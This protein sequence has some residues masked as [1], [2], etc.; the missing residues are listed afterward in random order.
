MVEILSNK[1]AASR[2]QIMVA[3]AAHE[4]GLQQKDI[5]QQI[6]ITPQA[7]S[8]YV[9]ELVKRGMLIYEG[10]SQ[11]R[12]SMEGVDW[13]LRQMLEMAD[14]LEFA[15]RTVANIQVSAAIAGCDLEAGQQVGLTMRDGLL[16]ATDKTNTEATGKTITAAGKGEDVGITRI[17]G[18]IKLSAGDVS[19]IEIATAREGGSKQADSRLLREALS[20]HFPVVAQGI[21]AV[22]ALKKAAVRFNGFHG[23]AEVALDAARAGLSPAVVSTRNDIP[24][25]LNRLEK[26]GLKY[27]LVNVNKKL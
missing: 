21:E 12:V 24:F 4:P 8:S 26:A 5:A 20:N 19:I 13:I 27:Y 25:L 17:K 3:I 1:N 23:A 2:F 6:G 9:R 11:Y 15:E 18:I 7:I 14:Y 10:R 16:Y 22:A